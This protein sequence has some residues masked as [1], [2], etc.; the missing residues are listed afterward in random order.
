MKM[1][2]NKQKFKDLLKKYFFYNRVLFITIFAIT[3][4]ILFHIC[5]YYSFLFAIVELIL[6][7]LLFYIV[8]ES[9]QSRRKL[10]SKTLELE[11]S[12]AWLS[13][14][15][16]SSIDAIHVLDM[17]GRLVEYSPSLLEILGYDESEASNLTIYD[18][19][20]K[21]SKMEIHAAIA[22]VGDIP[23]TFETL[24]KKKDGTVFD[25]EITARKIYIDGSEYR[26]ASARDITDHKRN[27]LALEDEKSTVQNYLDIVNVMILVL[28]SSKKIR[29]LNRRGCEIMGYSFDEVVGKDWVENFLPKRVQNDVRCVGDRL[30]NSDKIA[31]YY[32]NSVLRKDKEERL[33]A[34]RNTPL[35]DKNGDFD[36][37]LCSG[38][39]ITEV[40]RIQIELQ[41]SKDFYQTMFTSLNDAIIILEDNIVT[42]C[43]ESALYIFETEK[44]AFIGVNI[45]D[46]VHDIECKEDTFYY[47]LDSAY[48]GEYI[49]AECSLHLNTTSNKV[50][51]IEFTLSKFGG[52]D[53]NKLI[54]VARDITKQ[55]ADEKLFIMR[56]REAQMG[57][58]ISMI[59]HQWRQPLAI[60]SA[61]V[62]QMYLK[63]MMNGEK[64]TEY[65][66]NLM[67]I[68]MQSV[69]LSQTISDYRNFFS[70]DKLK[71]YFHISSLLKNVLSLMDHTIKSYSI[72]FKIDLIHDDTIYTYRNE[73]LQVLIALLKNS[74]DMFEENRV[75]NGKIIITVDHN[76]QYC[77]ISVFD[78][79][80]GISKENMNKLFAPYF[81]T[82]IKNSGTGLGLYMSKLIIHEHCNGSIDVFSQANETIFT[83]KLPYEK[84]TS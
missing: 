78:N 33:I 71:E 45:L 19:E 15:L 77:L 18:F 66:E 35:F 73:V 31:S 49:T 52:K 57:E 80:G 83:L 59:A 68:E 5:F 44:P 9:F 2:F 53:E 79:A 8:I 81:T 50:K 62:A 58:M 37:I 24:W 38:E 12:Q 84:E 22:A 4:L 28:D 69:H 72:E 30:K 42:D 74:L 55:V 36:G 17:E 41:N 60:I 26:Y 43:N 75:T 70:P 47:Y 56:A 48:Q 1:I 51:I 82:K 46:A 76:D 6:F 23:M 3:I 67:Q 10:L 63:S 27:Q 21:L 25:M 32:E 64:E 13:L 14:M 11:S 29:L 20:A 40:R 65:T 34:W 7:F 61:I 39:D 54:M 16:N